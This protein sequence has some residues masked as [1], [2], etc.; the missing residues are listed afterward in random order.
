[1]PPATS[2]WT[3]WS[4]LFLL[5]AMLMKTVVFLPTLAEAFFFL[6]GSGGGGGGGGGGGSKLPQLYQCYFNGQLINQVT[7]ATKA[8]LKDGIKKQEILFPP[9]PNLE[10]LAFGTSLNQAYTKDVAGRLKTELYRVKKDTV[11]FANVDHGNRIAAGLGGAVKGKTFLL[12]VDGLA[13]DS[14]V[15]LAS[16]TTV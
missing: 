10:E 7:A 12:S 4:R 3:T 1:M 2:A 9:V 14:E 8:A 16:K 11:A 15:T 5:T 13:K 6:G